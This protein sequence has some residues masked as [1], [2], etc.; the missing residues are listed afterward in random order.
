MQVIKSK[1]DKSIT[2]IPISDVHLGSLDCNELAWKQFCNDIQSQDNT[3]IVLVGDLINN[4]VRNSI[5]NPFDETLRPL[6][7]KKRMI[8]YLKP[9][10]HKILA[11]VTGNH[12]Y[13][14][15]KESDQ[16]ITY[17]ILCSLD[18]EYVYKENIAFLKIQ[19]GNASYAIAITHGNGAGCLTGA[20][21]N[22]NERYSYAIEGLDCFITA[23]THK[24]AVTRPNRLVFNLNCS[25]VSFKPCTVV[26]AE[27]WLNYGGYAAR[28]MMLP[29]ESCNPQKL[30]FNADKHNKKITVEW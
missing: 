12:E 22:K 27:S 1:F 19:C 17:D 23:H 30:R 18:L 4:S 5:A 2:L 24:G 20:A 3:Y 26:T 9:I 13:R 15:Q 28:K 29:A 14:T 16:D 11:A 7:Q 10:K 8:A 21:I 6:E 25:K